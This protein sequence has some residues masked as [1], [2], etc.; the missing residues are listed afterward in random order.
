MTFASD[1]TAGASPEI[2]AALA[3]V[4]GGRLP[5]YGG[6]PVTA[7]LTAKFCDLFEREVA[8]FPV[9]SGTAANAI[10]LSCAVPPWGV[11]FCHQDAHIEWDECAA[12][13]LITGGAKI[14][15]IAGPQGK[16]TPQLIADRLAPY[17]RG[18]QHQPQPAAISITQSTEWGT[19]YS[20]DEVETIGAFAKTHALTLH[21]D[22]ARFANALASTNASPADLT[23]RAGVDILSFGATKN[24]ALMA[25][26]I[27]VFKP[28]LAE[29]LLFRRKRAGHLISKMRFVSAQLNAYL[30]GGLMMRNAHAANNA[31]KRLADGLT[32]FDGVRLVMPVEAN[33][34]FAV[35]PDH[36]AKGLA[37]RGHAFYPWGAPADRVYRFVTAFDTTQEQVDSF[38]LDAKACFNGPASV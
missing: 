6:D 18:D 17:R 27:V 37:D 19:V 26:A 15:T 35:L 28:A 2:I 21:M 11:I 23:W 8:V 10:G 4:N 31:A 13:E 3:E 20:K 33:A 5:S 22:G 7:E 29:T 32:Q 14:A 16:L 24:G 1:N 25:E 36:L 38:L 9:V 30:S 12:P 34:V